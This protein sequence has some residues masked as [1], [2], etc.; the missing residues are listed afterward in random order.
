MHSM[1]RSA[2]LLLCVGL[3]T[4]A[5]GDPAADVRAERVAKAEASLAE[6]AAEIQERVRQTCE[7][8]QDR[9]QR[10]DR[11]RVQADLLD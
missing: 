9:D 7:R 4:L 8:W 6:A 1:L 2:S 3:S 5:C 11:E 10:C